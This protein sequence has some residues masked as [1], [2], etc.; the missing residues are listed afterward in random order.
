M[1]ENLI[2]MLEDGSVILMLGMGFVLAF[3]CILVFAMT[4]MSKVVC[5]L[6]KLYPEKVVELDKQ[7]K[8]PNVSED[9]AVA[10]AIAVAYSKA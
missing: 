1:S 7:S 10:L 8:K 2:T 4:I 9:E 3:L 6:N 5:Y